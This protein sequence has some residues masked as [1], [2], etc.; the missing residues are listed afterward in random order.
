MISENLEKIK[1]IIPHNHVVFKINAEKP[2]SEVNLKSTEWAIITQ[3]DGEKTLQEIIDN[4]SLTEEESLPLFYN[5]LQHQL[6]E[7]KDLKKPVKENAP[8]EFFKRLEEVLV[9]VIGPVASYI[10]DDVLWELSETR[11]KFL[12]EKIPLLIESISQEISD[13]EKRFEFQQEMLGVIKHI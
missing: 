3:I 12:K 13:E 11:D 4:L 7:I 2:P 6:I 5:L 10:I 1:E 8:P 9:K